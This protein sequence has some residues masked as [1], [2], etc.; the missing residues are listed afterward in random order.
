[1]E[2]VD[3]KLWEFADYKAGWP[4]L[5]RYRQE[6]DGKFSAAQVQ[7]AMKRV[8][9]SPEQHMKPRNTPAPQALKPSAVGGVQ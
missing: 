6:R 9:E 8:E 2:G 7:S 1:M 3:L 4:M 5:W